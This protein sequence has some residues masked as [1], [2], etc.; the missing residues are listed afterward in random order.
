MKGEHGSTRF[1]KQCLSEVVLNVVSV[2]VIA[3]GPCGAEC[4]H[5]CFNCVRALWDLLVMM[6]HLE[7]MEYRYVAVLKSEC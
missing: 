1:Y 2:I 4:D 5:C 7:M 6:G 3:L